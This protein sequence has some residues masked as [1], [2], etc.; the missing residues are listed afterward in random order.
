MRLRERILGTDMS[1]PHLEYGKDL[2]TLPPA[3]GVRVLIV[4]DHKLFADALRWVLQS[5]GMQV[6][7]VTTSGEEALAIALRERPELVLLDV[8]L[9]GGMSGLSLGKHIL[10]QLPETKVVAL[11]AVAHPQTVKKAISVG[12][13]GYVTL[14]N[15]MEQFTAS[16]QAVLAGQVVIP[17]QLARPSSG[18]L[19]PGEQVDR[20]LAEQL[21]LREREILAL[22]VD[23][24]NNQQIA[25]RLGISQNTARAHAQRILTKLQVHSRLEAAAFAVRHSLVEPTQRDRYDFGEAP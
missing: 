21:S 10:Q 2:E 7:G 19:S 16:L 17:Q 8:G 12:F 13:H 18:L 9:P 4:E 6:V 14:D 23:G 22:L 24:L 5:R 11:T 3:E 20:A 1:M 25:Q 15:P